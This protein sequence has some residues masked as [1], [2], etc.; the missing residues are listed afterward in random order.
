VDLGALVLGGQVEACSNMFYSAPSNVLRPGLA[1]V[2][3]DGWETARRRDDGNDWVV[4]RLALP[5]ELH[6]VVIDTSR[7]VGNAPGWAR[8]T[9]AVTGFELLPHQRLQPDTEQVFRTVP[10]PATG[11]VRLDVYPDG[12]ISRL[13]LLGRV[14]DSARADAVARWLAL[15]PAAVAATV[16]PTE[17]FA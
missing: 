11:L 10:P 1:G 15:L 9:D 17:F 5:G 3:S 12:G 6:A 14:A 4:V 7:F 2:M 16:D 13:R 8:L